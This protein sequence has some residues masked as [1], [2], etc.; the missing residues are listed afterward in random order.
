VKKEHIKDFYFYKAKREKYSARSVYKLKNIQDKY[1]LFSRGNRVLDLG[2]SPG[3]WTEYL[4]EQLGRTGTIVALDQKPL[5]ITCLGKIEKMGIQFEFLQ[6]SVFDELPADLPAMDAVVS[7]LAPATQGA[8]IVDQ[9]GSL[10]LIE[11]AHAIAEK[12][13]KKGG[14][15]VVKLFQSEDTVKLAKSWEKKFK[16]GKLYKPPA[17]HKESKEIYFVGC[18]L[19][20]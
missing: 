9:A 5:S 18:H 13:L 12:H 8:K 1:H 17:T 20:A 15:F 11:R 16:L 10:A 3:S 14:H 19:Q 2:A 6:Q 4:I 7:D